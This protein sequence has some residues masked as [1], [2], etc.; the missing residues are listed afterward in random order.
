MFK[1]DWEKTSATHQLP[2]GLVEKMLRLAYLNKKLI[3]YELI[4]GGC[5]NL[6]FKILLEYDKSFLILR[7]YLRDKEAAYRE[8]KITNLLKQ[9]VPVP[10]TYYIGQINGYTFAIN[11]FIFKIHD[12][13]CNPSL[14]RL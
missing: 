13:F 8:Q 4:A 1:A 3:S 11:E 14:T 6:N 9:S 10:Q 12:I 2:E 7:I 5:A